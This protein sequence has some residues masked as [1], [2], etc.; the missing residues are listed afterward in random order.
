[1]SSFRGPPTETEEGIEVIDGA[2]V[3]AQIP[4]IGKGTAG[5]AGKADTRVV[6]G[7]ASGGASARAA[8][9][10]PAGGPDEGYLSLL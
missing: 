1:M 9:H 7:A 10:D 4:I 8:V 6:D 2:T 3:A 5:K